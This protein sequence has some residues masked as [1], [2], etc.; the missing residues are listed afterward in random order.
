MKLSGK[1][2]SRY[3]NKI[4]WFMKTSVLFTILLYEGDVTIVSH[5][6]PTS[7]RENSWYR[8]GMN[9]LAYVTVTRTK[10]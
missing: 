6:L 8:Y 7:W 10:Q 4:G 1:D 9:K 2:L 5:S 3:S